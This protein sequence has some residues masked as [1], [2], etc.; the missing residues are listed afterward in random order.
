VTAISQETTLY[1]IVASH[2]ATRPNALALS[3]AGFA[4]TYAE[5]RALADRLASVLSAVPAEGHRRIAVVA[6]NHP[7]TCLVYLAA[8][9]AGAIV[10]LVNSHFKA[11]ELSGVLAKLEPHLLIFDAAHR[12]VV[13][14]ALAGASQ[15]PRFAALCRDETSE[16]PS[17]E[18]WLTATSSDVPP[19]TVCEYAEISWTSGTTSSPKGVMLT[20]ATV[21]ARAQC[22]V[23]LFGL[24]GDDT[25]AVITPL[26]H[27]SGIRNTVVVMWVCGGHAVVLPKFDVSTFWADM[28]RHR[29]T[30]LC[31]VETI[32]AMLERQ[33]PSADEAESRVRV[34]LSN[35]DPRIIQK[36][37]ERFRFRTVQVWGMT[38]AGVATGVPRFLPLEEVRALRTAV[39]GASLAGWPIGSDTHIRLWSDDGVITEPSVP[40]EIQMASPLLFDAY[41]RESEATLAAFDGE[42]MKTGDLGVFGPSG[43]LYFMDRLKDVI[44][45]GG[46]NIASKQV[47]EV[48]LAH[49]AVSNA[50]VIPVPDPVFVQEVKA[51]LVLKQ[52]VSADEL[53]SW[54]DERLARYKVPRYIEVTAALPVNA[55]G[56]V[57]KQRLVA[58]GGTDRGV[59]FDRRTMRG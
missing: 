2:A 38:E 21:I 11:P 19:G 49:P 51:V 52:S 7:F 4:W 25:A 45:R 36:C 31:M 5:L 32:L 29:V 57:Q 20:H 24:S 50:A 17:V 12:E 55:S 48:L 30:Y 8:A 9:R 47:E 26:F 46:E 23:E 18:E 33:P 39:P 6:D 54:C 28:R 16:H 15:Q 59:V 56:R 14:A 35:G 10:S 41:Y 42:W 43:A 37:E 53:W 40:G 34:V 1:S 27:Q 13:T 3:G 58:A 22:E 44:R